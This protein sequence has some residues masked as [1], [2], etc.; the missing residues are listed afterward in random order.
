MGLRLWILLAMG[1]SFLA[2]VPAGVLIADGLRPPAEPDGPF[3]DYAVRLEREFDLSPERMLVLRA[4]L[5]D[6]ER[7]LDEVRSRQLGAFEDEIVR[8]GR[9]CH[10][11]IRNGL[12][13][14]DT[15]R[16]RFDALSGP[17]AAL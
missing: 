14:Q 5:I 1:V 17:F 4:V 9:L 13:P 11:R 15:D 16:E 8:L 7:S 10:D 6:Y 2:G 12:L 3:S